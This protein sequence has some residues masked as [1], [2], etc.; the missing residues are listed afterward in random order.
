MAQIG[1]ALTLAQTQQLSADLAGAVDGGDVF[2]AMEN[3][4]VVFGGLTAVSKVSFKL[5]RRDLVGLI[6]PNGAGKTTIF[7]LITGVYVPTTGR[8]LFN[9]NQIAGPVN[10]ERGDA[11]R[12]FRKG[13]RMTSWGRR[14]IARAGICRTFQ[15]IRLFHGLSVL[16]NVLVASHSRYR[17]SIGGAMLRSARYYEAESG[18][19]EQA[20][21]LLAA[22]KLLDY[23]HFLAH[24][25]PYGAQRRLEIARA[26]ATRPQL[27]LLD[28]PAA[29]MNPQ[30]SAEL[31]EMIRWVR[32]NYGLTI[33]LIEHDMKVVMGM[34]ERIL[35]LDNGCVIADG[36]PAEVRSDPRVVTAY[37]GTEE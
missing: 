34:C 17:Q 23:E 20:H 8:I 4:S 33:L 30:E 11:K 3:C 16:Q 22:L 6:G 25:L 27:L 12:F 35:V 36:A 13:S 7:N 21:A 29:G 14:D 19:R 24:N 28:E 15:N 26:L 18:A 31:M 32:E 2:F 1:E 37:L 9:G 5:G 10:Q